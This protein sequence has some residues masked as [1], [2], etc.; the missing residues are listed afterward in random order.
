[1]LVI[2]VDTRLPVSHPTPLHS[3]HL[4]LQIVHIT[5]LL[6]EHQSLQMV[7][8]KKKPTSLAVL[9]AIPVILCELLTQLFTQTAHNPMVP[10]R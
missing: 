9:V 1:M 4:A 6:C 3:F 2:L 10:S 8:T 5:Y 7:P